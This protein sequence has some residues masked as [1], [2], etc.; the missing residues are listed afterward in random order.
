MRLIH[1]FYLAAGLAVAGFFA[2]RAVLFFPDAWEAFRERDRKPFHPIQIDSTVF[3]GEPSGSADTN[4]L[5]QDTSLIA[6]LSRTAP[7]LGIASRKMSVATVDRGG[8][9]LY[10]LDFRKGVPLAERVQELADSLAVR[11][12]RLDESAERPRTKYP[13]AAR[14]H[15]GEQVVALLR[16]RS[17]APPGPGTFRLHVC[18]WTDSLTVPDL[19]ALERFPAGVMLALA[20]RDFAT[21]Q[22]SGIA[23]TR[24]LDLAVLVRLETS[25]YPVSLQEKSRVLLHH[26]A[27]GISRRI[28]ASD[29]VA[30]LAKGLVAMDG[31]RGARDPGLAMRLAELMKRRSWW[32]LDAT[33]TSASRLEDAAIESSLGI[34]PQARKTEDDPAVGLELAAVQA[35]S[36]GE[37]AVMVKLDST[38]AAALATFVPLVRARGISIAPWPVMHRRSTGD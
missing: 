37:A 8:L 17:F 31:D 36:D 20:P 16:G 22:L 9:P 23:R 15:R 28:L 11:G 21:G 7:A 32:I 13:W 27:D 34:L 1:G 33:R 35:E 29:S 3:D 26:D 6:L 2:W 38:S 19:A 30:T 25:L 24:G 5:V 14:L 10:T 18:F 12:F 4:S